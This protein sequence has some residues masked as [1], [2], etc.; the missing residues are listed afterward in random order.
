MEYNYKTSGTCSVHISFNIDDDVVSNI[1]F[2]GGCP[3]NLKAISKLL[4]GKTKE[5]KEHE[6]WDLIKNYLDSL[7]FNILVLHNVEYMFSK[8][9]GNLSKFSPSIKSLTPS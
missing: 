4:D 6:T 5:E 2:M 8:E 3:G 7:N 9:L 1:K